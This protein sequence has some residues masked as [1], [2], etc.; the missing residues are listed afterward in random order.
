MSLDLSIVIPLYQRGAERPGAP[1]RADG[2]PGGNRALLRAHLCRRRQHGR[3]VFVSWASCTPRMDT[4][5]SFDCVEISGK[6]RRSLLDSAVRAVAS[7]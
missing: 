4:S 7:S 2:N 6:P 5:A 3:H 1:S